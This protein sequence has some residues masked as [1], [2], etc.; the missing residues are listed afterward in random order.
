LFNF[1][2]MQRNLQNAYS[3]A[4]NFDIEQQLGKSSSV[5]VGYEH[6]RGL[7]L[8]ASINRNVPTCVASAGNNG[9]R[10]DPTYGNNSQYSSRADSQ[11]DGLHVSFVQRPAKWGNYRISY[12][13]SKALDNVGEFFFSSPL[14]NFNIWQDYGRSDDDQRHRFVFDGSI[15]TP[16]GHAST[17]WEHVSHEFELTALVQY[18]S[19]VPLNIT[20]GSTT[21]QGTAARPM[22][23]GVYIGRNVGSG[24]GFFNLGG[25][26]SRNFQ[27]SD[28][29]RLNAIAEG[30]NLTN[31]VN[32]VS[33]NGVFGTGSYP[34]SPAPNFGQITAVSD[35]RTFQFAL[36][37]AF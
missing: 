22:M 36:R 13:Y 3:E 18:Y 25:R 9:C 24:P 23:N 1:T 31:H 32:G 4:G 7:H 21:V 29:L 10:P 14:N 20:T 35:P 34:N 33:V 6:V 17:F 12:T 16:Q 26:L 30:F 11:Y 5:E 27:I 37:L 15:H 8:I 28:R 2:T 19:S